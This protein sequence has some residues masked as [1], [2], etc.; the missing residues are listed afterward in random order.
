MES[1]ARYYEEA[2]QKR[3]LKN[4]KQRAQEFG[5]TLTPLAQT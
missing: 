4:L 5:F 3:C 1:G 2:Y